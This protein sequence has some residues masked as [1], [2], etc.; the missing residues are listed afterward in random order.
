MKSLAKTGRR[1]VLDVFLGGLLCCRG[2]GVRSV[3]DC[4]CGSCVLWVVSLVV[5]TAGVGS[6]G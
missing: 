1:P 3:V 2:V 4:E 6:W 5:V